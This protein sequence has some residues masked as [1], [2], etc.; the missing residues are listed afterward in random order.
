M[1]R[2]AVGG[3]AGRRDSANFSPAR[4]PFGVTPSPRIRYAKRGEVDIA[5]QVLGEGP[6]DLLLLTGAAI[7]IEC[8]DDEP[9]LA[10]FQRRLSSFGRLLP[11]DGPGIGLSDRGSP[12]TPPTLEQRTQAA[13]AVLD[14]VGSERAAVVAP[15]ADSAVV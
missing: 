12:S 3:D 2:P 9:S 8:M 13:V 11:Y 14:A 5:Y 10:R 7:P 6:T 15:L 1:P 4:Y